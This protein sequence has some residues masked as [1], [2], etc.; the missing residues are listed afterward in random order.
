MSRNPNSP[1]TTPGGSLKIK[2][3]DMDEAIYRPGVT[4]K[5][6]KSRPLSIPYYNPI[7]I[8]GNKPGYIDDESD[9]ESGN[10][11]HGQGNGPA[12]GRGG[13]AGGNGN[14]NGGGNV[15]GTGGGNVTSTGGNNDGNGN[16]SG[17]G[18]GNGNGNGGGGQGPAPSSGL[19]NRRSIHGYDSTT[20]NF[21]AG[22]QFYPYLPSERNPNFQFPKRD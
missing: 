19:G 5:I 11:T 2:T 17:N 3:I 20:G 16:G 13:G 21:M 10:V 18:S 7:E 22:K 9:S 15:T 1:P 6:P 12:G 14:D 4:P 8:F